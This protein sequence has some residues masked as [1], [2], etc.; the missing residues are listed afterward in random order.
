MFD[1]E[2]KVVHFKEKPGCY[3][4]RRYPG[5]KGSVVDTRR[6]AYAKRQCDIR[7][8]FVTPVVWVVKFEEEIGVLEER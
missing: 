2:T 6:L 3:Y 1:L 7:Y 5:W 4:M 8:Q